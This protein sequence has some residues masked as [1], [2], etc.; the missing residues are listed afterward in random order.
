MLHNRYSMDSG[1][2][3]QIKQGRAC[4]IQCLAYQ[5]AHANFSQIVGTCDGWMPRARTARRRIPLFQAEIC[6]EVRSICQQVQK[7]LWCKSQD[8]N[9][10]N[11]TNITPHIVRTHLPSSHRFLAGKCHKTWQ[12]DQILDGFWQGGRKVG[13]DDVWVMLVY[14]RYPLLRFDPLFG[15]SLMVTSNRTEIPSNLMG[16]DIVQI[17]YSICA[18]FSVRKK[19][20]NM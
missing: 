13:P 9:I 5:T 18:S 14:Y 1:G 6:R 3:Y 15:L 2:R 17:F 10:N 20:Q 19:V 16:C 12:T 7:I 4:Q 11:N 8:T